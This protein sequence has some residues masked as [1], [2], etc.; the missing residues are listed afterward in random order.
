MNEGPPKSKVWEID[1][2]LMLSRL[3]AIEKA[4]IGTTSLTAARTASASV[5][6]SGSP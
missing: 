5:G 6:P 1:A 2:A 3:P 4:R